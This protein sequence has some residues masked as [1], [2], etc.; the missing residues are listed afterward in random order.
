MLPTKYLGT[1][2]TGNH[3]MKLFMREE[4]SITIQTTHRFATGKLL[5]YAIQRAYKSFCFY[6]SWVLVPGTAILPKGLLAIGYCLSLIYLF[7]GIAIVSDV[8]MS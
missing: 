2:K 4:G 6:Q 5:I 7:L 1:T 3:R 8:F